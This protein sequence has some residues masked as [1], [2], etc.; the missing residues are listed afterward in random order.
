MTQSQDMVENRSN[1]FSYNRPGEK[2]KTLSYKLFDENLTLIKKEKLVKK[3][4]KK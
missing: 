1:H 4:V 3:V 2:L